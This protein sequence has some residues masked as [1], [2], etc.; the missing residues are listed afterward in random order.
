NTPP[1]EK[2]IVLGNPSDGSSTWNGPAHGN[3]HR[4]TRPFGNDSAKYNTPPAAITIDAATSRLETTYA[5]PPGPQPL[6]GQRKIPPST[7]ATPMNTSLPSK[8]IAAAAVSSG[9]SKMR[10]GAPPARGTRSRS[11]V[12]P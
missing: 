3:T 7:I 11:P 12:M 2:A 6:F 5:P 9:P 10:S 8:A 1:S 4:P